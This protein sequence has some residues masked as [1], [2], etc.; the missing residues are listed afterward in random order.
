MNDAV[1]PIVFGKYCLLERI[2]VGGMAEV[3]RARPFHAPKFRRYLAVKRILP[4]L[5]EDTQFID[6]FVDEAKI[7]VQLNHKR[8]CQIYEL[9]RLQD[10]FYIV[11]EYIAGKNLLQIQNHF[12][13]QKKM[14][15]VTQAAFITQCICEGLDYAH[16]KVSDDGEPMNIIHRDVSPQ[17]ILVSF[18]GEV[19]VIDFGIAKAA[20]KN[21]QTQVGVLKGKFGYMSPEQAMGQEIDHRSD[22]FAVG[23]LMWEMLTSR[24]LFHGKT[25]FETLEKVRNADVPP[26]SSRNSRI[27][28]EVDRIILKALARDRNER[29]QW[30]SEFAHDLRTFL[31][32]IRPPYTEESLSGWMVTNF[33]DE[34]AAEKAKVPLFAPFVTV[35]DVL[36]H[37]AQTWEEVG[38][39]DLEEVDGD[40]ATRVVDPGDR[41]ARRNFVLAENED[42][43]MATVVMNAEDIDLPDPARRGQL[44]V[45]DLEPAPWAATRALPAINMSAARPRRGPNPVLLA[46]LGVVVLAVLA[47]LVWL[48]LQPTTATLVVQTQPGDGVLVTV[49]GA[50]V[51]GPPPWTIRDLEPG[52]VTISVLHPDYLPVVEG[53]ELV[54]GQ[55]TRW[56][57]TLVPAPRDGMVTFTVRPDDAQLYLDGNRIAAT[58]PERTFSAS[59]GDRHVVE[60]YRE[61]HFVET[62]EFQLRSAEE[63]RRS[64]EL[65]PV[66]GTLRITSVP[67][68]TVFLNGVERGNTSDRLVLEGLDVAQVY[69]LEIRPSQPGYRPLTQTVVFDAFYDFRLSPRLPRLGET[70]TPPPVEWGRL[71]TSEEQTFFRVFVDGRDTGFVTP[72]PETRPLPLRAGERAIRFVRAGDEREVTVS[73][74]V[75]GDIQVTIP[76]RR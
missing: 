3:F 28:P 58:G 11:M 49:N 14:M 42:E 24:R 15:S 9:G 71:T 76:P 7:T 25:D 39:D 47:T 35:Q 44:H 63:F 22:V 4:N 8:I 32:N 12:R 2:S 40:D 30:A 55:T 62:F 6:M 36:Q 53:M 52:S 16:R 21:Q 10:S 51:Q 18:D 45:D 64:V 54:A 13:A 73:V 29:Y 41:P 57:R 50:P 27:P 67:E 48:W 46:S 74:P 33:P 61:G 66:T 37:N 17:N 59:A 20:S 70:G 26:P 43:P 68:G 34:I 38:E 60:I 69:E 72:I 56:Q 5:A 1:R 23:A 75:G 31:A 19:K 65:R